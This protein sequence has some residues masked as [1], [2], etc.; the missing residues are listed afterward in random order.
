[1]ISD[2]RR[3]GLR[4]L[5]AP[6]V[7]VAAVMTT[8]W[9]GRE[10]GRERR[11]ERDVLTVGKHAGHR[12]ALGP[13]QPLARAGQLGQ[14]VRPGPRVRRAVEALPGLGA[15]PAGSRRRSRRPAPRARAPRRPAPTPAVRQRGGRPHRAPRASPRSSPPARARAAA[16]DAAG[17]SA[18]SDSRV[19]HRRGA[20]PARRAPPAQR[21]ARAG[22]SG[23]P[24]PRSRSPRP[25]RSESSWHEN[26]EKRKTMPSTR[27]SGRKRSASAPG[28]VGRRAG[29]VSGT[30]SRGR[31]SL[32]LTQE[33][34]LEPQMEPRGPV[35]WC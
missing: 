27:G 14:A 10:T 26:T 9:R 18:S 31:C 24:R 4:L 35:R 3:F 33:P 6:E 19:L 34:D 23:S 21:D 32:A 15:R 17:A 30:G 7:P 1:M 13:P 2:P 22:A 8:S 5:P 16:R 20:C 28:H 12:D 29:A 25:P 11:V